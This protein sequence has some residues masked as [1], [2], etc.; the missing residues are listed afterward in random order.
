MDCIV[1]SLFPLGELVVL[2]IACACW[3]SVM[4]VPVLIVRLLVCICGGGLGRGVMAVAVAYPSVRQDSHPIIRFLMTKYE[5][6]D[7]IPRNHQSPLGII[8]H[9]SLDENL[10]SADLS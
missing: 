1:Y 7:L 2:L 5:P 6:S 3:A 9:R 8:Q 4:V 10:E